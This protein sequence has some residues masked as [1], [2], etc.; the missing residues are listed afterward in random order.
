MAQVKSVT[1]GHGEVRFFKKVEATPTTTRRNGNVTVKNVGQ[2]GSP[3]YFEVSYM[4]FCTIGERD[5]DYQNIIHCK[6]RVDEQDGMTPYFEI[7]D[8]AARQLA[9]MLREIADLVDAQV[10]AGDSQ[11]AD[12]SAIESNDAGVGDARS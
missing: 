10:T 1:L 6:V 4:I 7:E 3:A 11:E 12:G 5:H 8:A 2:P 9:P